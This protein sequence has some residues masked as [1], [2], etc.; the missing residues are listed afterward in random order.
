[1]SLH[2]RFFNEEQAEKTLQ[3]AREY[4]TTRL[5]TDDALTLE[6]YLAAD[7]ILYAAIKEIN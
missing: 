1:M 3:H 5:E 7:D 4:L 6:S 2:I